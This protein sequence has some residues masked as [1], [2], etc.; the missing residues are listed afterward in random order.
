MP[1]LSYASVKKNGLNDRLVMVRS[2]DTGI[3][4]VGVLRELQTIPNAGG[5][6]LLIDDSLTRKTFGPIHSDDWI[7]DPYIPTTKSRP[8]KHESIEILPL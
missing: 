7:L 1:N 3:H 8:P 2:C 4:Y 5:V 6:Y